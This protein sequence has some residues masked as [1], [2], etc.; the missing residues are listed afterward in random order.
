MVKNIIYIDNDL[1]NST[2]AQNDG[3][4]A[5]SKSDSLSNTKTESESNNGK[6]SLSAKIKVPFSEVEAGLGGGVGHRTDVSTAESQLLD[7]VFHDYSLNILLDEL[8]DQLKRTETGL[9][10]N[11]YVVFNSNFSAY[12]FQQL[13]NVTDVDVFKKFE[14]SMNLANKDEIQELKERIKQL[15]KAP[16][17]DRTTIAQIE[18]EQ[19]SLEHS[20]GDTGDIF[21]LLNGFAN[22]ADALYPNTVLFST[23]NSITLANKKNFRISTSQISSLSNASHEIK[24]FGIVMSKQNSDTTTDMSSFTPETINTIPNI[25]SNILLDS[26]N[27]AKQ[28]TNVILPIAIYFE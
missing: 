21:K 6:A 3:G 26:F 4:V 8:S 9:S 19:K 25:L 13:K 2:I 27:I 17:K 16:N 15:K 1:L 10:I 5:L 24:I 20:L 28:G 11:D 7:T 22:L 12:D 18:Q 23:E 14:E